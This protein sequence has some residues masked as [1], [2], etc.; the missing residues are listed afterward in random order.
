MGEGF[1]YK[2]HWTT[3]TLEHRYCYIFRRSLFG[4]ALHSLKFQMVPLGRKLC[5]R[6]LLD[7]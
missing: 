7:W 4:R 5:R 2:R 1:E 3:Q 6:P